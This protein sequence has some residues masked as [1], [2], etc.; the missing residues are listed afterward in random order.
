MKR[1]DICDFL[2]ILATLTVCVGFVLILILTTS[3]IMELCGVETPIYHDTITV[4]D[5]IIA[6]QEAI[7]EK[8]QDIEDNVS[9]IN[10]LLSS[11]SYGED[12]NEHS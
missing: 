12:E 7:N 10:E 3:L 5:E 8:A 9:R 4:T 1:F 2:I 6:Q 11:I